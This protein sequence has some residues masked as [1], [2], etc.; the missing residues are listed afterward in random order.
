MDIYLQSL[1]AIIHVANSKLTMNYYII[2]IVS[3]S[4]L[5]NCCV[6]ASTHVWDM[7]YRKRSTLMFYYAAI[8]TDIRLF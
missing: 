3:H 2:T 4:V 5:N 1:A 8:D 7:F 6:H